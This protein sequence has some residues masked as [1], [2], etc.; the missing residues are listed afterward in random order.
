MKF[1]NLSR[2]DIDTQFD[3]D[4]NGSLDLQGTV[5]FDLRNDEAFLEQYQMAI[6][7]CAAHLK[8]VL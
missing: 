4:H 3:T 6:G 1:E 7:L 5:F 2:D 8:L